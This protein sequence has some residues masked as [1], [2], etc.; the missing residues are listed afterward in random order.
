[1]GSNNSLVE[2]PFPPTNLVAQRPS[3]DHESQNLLVR[4]SDKGRGD[5]RKPRKQKTRARAGRLV[6][7]A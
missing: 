1:M 2:R 4:T 5:K 3:L 7:S 6:S